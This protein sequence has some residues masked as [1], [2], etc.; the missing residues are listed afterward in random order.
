MHSLVVGNHEY[1]EGWRVFFR[2]ED[3]APVIAGLMREADPN[4]AAMHGQILTLSA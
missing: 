3:D 4:P 1:G 2:Y